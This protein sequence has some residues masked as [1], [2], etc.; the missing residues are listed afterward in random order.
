MRSS[1]AP[2]VVGF[3]FASV[4]ALAFARP[5][6][7]QQ[8]PL[9]FAVER[10]Y[11]SAPGAGWLVMDTL[12]MHGGIGGAVAFSTGYARNPV[13]VASTDGSQRFSLVSDQAFAAVSAAVTYSRFRAYVD[14]TKP[15]LLRGQS[16]TV[17]D[18]A[19]SAPSSDGGQSPDLI[20]DV[21][22]GFD[23][24]LV[25]EH[26]APLRLGVGAQLWV[27]SGERI[28][29]VTDGTVRAMGRVL[30]AGDAGPFVY[31]GHVGIHLR[32]LDD[33]PAP[34]SPRGS[35]L[36][37]GVAGGVRALV[38]PTQ[39]VVVGPE[40]YGATAFSAFGATTATALEALVSARLEGTKDQGAALRLKLGAGGGLNAHF[41]APDARVVLAIE[42][43][44]HAEAVHPHENPAAGR[45]PT[46]SYAALP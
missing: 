33:S 7:A 9:G 23:A 12:D 22:L 14:L 32:P 2:A 10:L 1:R 16:G 43:F 8:Q 31:A 3:A 17:G 18:F 39:A 4:L 42:L 34:G 13:R 45:P 25:G 41:G 40:I 35:E 46:P 27:P 6:G 44:G 36:L 24:R 20:S 37:F 15:M 30:V 19:V 5:A 21:R 28:D 26:D 11:T 38:S 29:Y